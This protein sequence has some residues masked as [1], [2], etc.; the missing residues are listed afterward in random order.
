MP[1]SLERRAKVIG[2]EQPMSDASWSL[3]FDEIWINDRDLPLAVGSLD[4]YLTIV[5]DNRE[6]K[7]WSAEVTLDGEHVY[8]KGEEVSVRGVLSDGRVFQ[9]KGWVRECA[10]TP[11]YTDITLSGRGGTLH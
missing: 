8:E 6:P 4:P 1:P 10:A 3:P 11:G 7:G 2:T 5:D 9:G